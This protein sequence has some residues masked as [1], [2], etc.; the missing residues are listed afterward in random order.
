M[1][2]PTLRT[3]HVETAASR[4]DGAPWRITV[5][6][7]TGVQPGPATAILS[8]ITGDKPLGVIAPTSSPPAWAAN[9]CTAPSS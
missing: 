9:P 4:I 1:T 3:W 8:G 6:E 2:T 7:F 5:Q